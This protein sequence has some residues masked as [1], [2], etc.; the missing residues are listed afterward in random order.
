MRILAS[1]V[2][3][4]IAFA[5]FAQP[6]GTDYRSLAVQYFSNG[7]YE[8]AAIYYEKLWNDTDSR[9]DFE[10]YYLCL[11]ELKNFKDAEKIIKKEAKKK[12]GPLT[13]YVLYGDLYAKQGDDN[14]ADQ[15]YNQAIKAIEPYH[16]FGQITRLANEFQVRLKID[17]AIEAYE[18]A[19]KMSPNPV[20]YNIRIGELYGVQGKTD[21][22]IREFLG[23]LETNPGYENQVQN[24]L[25]RSIDFKEDTRE[26]DQLKTELLKLAQK[27]PNNFIYNEMLIWLFQQKGDFGAAFVQVKALDKKQQAGGQL[28]FEFGETCDNNDRYD[29]AIKAFQY[30]IDQ[31]KENRYYRTANYR[32]LNV[33]KR[34]ITNSPTYTQENLEDLEAKY[35]YTLN[36]VGRAPHSINLMKDLGHLQGFYL[37]KFDEAIELLE[38]AVELSVRTPKVQAECKMLLADVLVIQG[39]VWEASLLYSQVDLDFKEDVLSHEA[40]FK[41]AKIFYYTSNFVLA[42]SQLDVLKSSTQKLIAND[43]M[44]LSLLITDNLA[45]DTTANTMRLFADADLLITQLRFDEALAKFDSI[46]QALPYHSLNDEIL[47]KKYQIAYR[48]Q[49]YE[50]AAAFLTEIV[51]QY[52][53]DILADNALFL[54]GDM[55]QKVFKNDEKA[56]EYYFDLFTNYRGSMYGIEARK[57]WR[58]IKGDDPGSRSFKE[59]E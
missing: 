38:E 9:A 1:I 2:F 32:S 51:A 5:S 40:K 37:Q 22:M 30:V 17:K 25:L 6:G 19:K 8:K 52:G 4:C 36:E 15:Y 43:A 11:L 16:T 45:L 20:V 13:T 29:L 57:R 54:L 26:S 23:M 35:K 46:N 31:G 59:I 27:H 39:N 55:Y 44:E 14:K 49:N 10:K 42:Q 21:L 47:M 58:A 53:D 3:C 48:K 28:V 12:N 18:R 50:Q 33:L 56:A 41:N 34:K 24:A 7:D